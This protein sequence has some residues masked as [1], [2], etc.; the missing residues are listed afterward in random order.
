MKHLIILLLLICAAPLM[1]QT[2]TVNNSEIE[3]S[4]VRL[5]QP[6][7]DAH[8]LVKLASA[9]RIQ[10]ADFP[11]LAAVIRQHEALASQFCGGYPD[12]FRDPYSCSKANYPYMKALSKGN[13]ALHQ[14][15][16]K[17]KGLPT[18]S[19]GKGDVR[20]LTW[21]RNRSAWGRQYQ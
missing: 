11:L 4:L 1:A 6:S 9:D 2:S 8:R 17:A 20:W 18:W 19:W 16:E 12:Y 15:V 21:F 14:V 7:V 13:I 3:R 5:G 10:K